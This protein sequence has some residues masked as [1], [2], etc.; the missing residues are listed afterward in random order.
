MKKMYL[1][2]AMMLVL[3]LAGCG[4]SD[5]K[6]ETTKEETSAVSEQDEIDVEEQL[7]SEVVKIELSNDNI[8]VN[9]EKISKD[10]DAAVY[11]ANDIIFYLENQG[12]E[13][14]DGKKKDEHSQIEGDAHTVVHITEPGVYELTGIMDAG[15][16]FVD[17]GDGTK[18]EED[19]AA[20]LIL[21]DVDI[22]CR[23]R[24]I[25]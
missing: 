22:T 20:T 13:Y 17:L 25:L 6:E 7:F 11:A 16:I 4:K 5:K 15:Q 10:P 3:G 18:N 23:I 14:G 1:L 12:I 8:L 9:G 19:A 21:N 2:L 24:S